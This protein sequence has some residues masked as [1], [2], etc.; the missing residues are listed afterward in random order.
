[1][2]ST[3]RPVAEHLEPVGGTPLVGEVIEFDDDRGLGV[4]EYGPGERIPFHCTAISDGSRSVAVGTVVAFVVSAG[5][6][7]QLEARTVRPLP[8]VVPPGSTLGT[9]REQVDAERVAGRNGR[10]A[11][12]GPARLPRARA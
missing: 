11:G 10:R 5:R 2:T 7:G 9:G 12:S 3:E 6:L 8:G 1:M 4:V